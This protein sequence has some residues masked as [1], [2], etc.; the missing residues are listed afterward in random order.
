VSASEDRAAAKAILDAMDIHQR[1]ESLKIQAAGV[2]AVLAVASAI[3][4]VAEAYQRRTSIDALERRRP[5][6]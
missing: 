3:H 5:R 2:Q 6:W 4:E 1:S